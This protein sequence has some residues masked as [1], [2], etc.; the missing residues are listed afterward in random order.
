MIR[1]QTDP[2]FD[3]IGSYYDTLHTGIEL[4]DFN[5][6]FDLIEEFLTGQI[7]WRLLQSA[8]DLIGN[9]LSIWRVDRINI[10]ADLQ[11][12]YLVRSHVRGVVFTTS[13]IDFSNRK[14][15][16]HSVICPY[17]NDYPAAIQPEQQLGNVDIIPYTRFVDTIGEERYNSI[18]EFTVQDTQPYLQSMMPIYPMVQRGNL[19]LDTVEKRISCELPDTPL[20]VRINW[21]IEKLKRENGIATHNWG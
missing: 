8:D 4:F 16:F 3:F 6:T 14:V 15:R 5:G 17:N 18:L 2:R 1:A 11:A 12:T 21:I 13:I 7:E 19:N 9:P 10:V 20:E